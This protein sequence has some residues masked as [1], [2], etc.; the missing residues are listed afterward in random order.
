MKEIVWLK[1]KSYEVGNQA[2]SI[3]LKES[4]ICSIGTR[5]FKTPATDVNRTYDMFLG[6]DHSA[7]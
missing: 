7:H 3:N 1:K 5:K 6:I 2:T 4:E